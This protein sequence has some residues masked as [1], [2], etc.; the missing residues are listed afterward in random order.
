MCGTCMQDASR[1]CD[2]QRRSVPGLCSEELPKIQNSRVSDTRAP[3]V[4]LPLSSFAAVKHGVA[5]EQSELACRGFE[6]MSPKESLH[7]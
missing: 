2:A 6:P 3:D 1:K 5:S 4:K 7:S